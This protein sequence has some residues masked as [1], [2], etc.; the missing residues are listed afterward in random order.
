MAAGRTALLE[1]H[2]QSPASAVRRI[3][4]RVRRHA[5]AID[6]SYAIEGDLERIALPAARAPRAAE[7]LWEHTCC[8]LFVARK[9]EPGYREFNFSPSGEWAR[10]VFSGYRKPAAAMDEITLQTAFRREVD[11]LVLE[12]HLPLRIAGPLELA[13]S[14]V[15]EERGGVLSYWAL[16]HPPGKPDF[17]HR[18]AFA[19]ELDEI[20]D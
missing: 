1:C 8:E 9:G 16:R 4:V 18:D 5:G 6:A 2:A 14:A 10:Y 13:L 7:R 17:H 3:E 11:R 12:A 20:R 15:I 19:M